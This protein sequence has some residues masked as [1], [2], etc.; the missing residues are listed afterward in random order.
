MKYITKLYNMVHEH[1]IQTLEV[2]VVMFL[3]LLLS[4]DVFVPTSAQPLLFLDKWFVQIH[5]HVYGIQQ[6]TNDMCINMLNHALKT[7]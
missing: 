4:F 7:C 6:I 1:G 5:L 3:L 2:V